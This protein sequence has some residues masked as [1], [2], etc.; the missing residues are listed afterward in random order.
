MS[1]LQ[2]AVINPLADLELERLRSR[3]CAKW[4]V[5]PDDVLPLWVAEMD[6]VIA[7]PISAA[8]KDALDNG[9][10]GY[11]FGHGY[12][13]ALASFASD[14]W[15]WTFD[16]AATSMVAD[17]MSGVKEVARA[18][19]TDA[20]A[21]IVTPPVYP[22]FF[23][24]ANKLGRT[25][26]EAPLD[27]EGRLNQ[28]ALEAAFSEATAGGRSAVMLLCNPHN[29]TGTV[30]TRAELDARW[31]GSP[32]RCPR[33]LRRDSLTADHADRDLHPLPERRRRGKRLCG[34]V[35][36]QG[37]EPGRL[38]GGAGYRRP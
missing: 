36:L 10:T 5:Y 6:A 33:H 38:Q 15:G 1:A 8:V 7:P 32:V 20:S 11:P 2:E 19:G 23:G 28:A 26:V 34:G 37:L 30:H 9:D 24:V 17:V 27:A 14:R 21:V 18:L 13:E 12:A 29:P 22:P 25:I 16:P 31:A 35:G 3:T 4:S